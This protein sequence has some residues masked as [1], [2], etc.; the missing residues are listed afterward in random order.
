MRRAVGI[1]WLALTALA[2]AVFAPLPYVTT[3][4]SELAAD[5]S[6]LALN[7][8][9]RPSWLQAFFYAHVIGG[10]V[11]LL[12]SPVQLS[13]RIRARA[14]RLHRLSGRIVLT[15]VMAAGVAG[16][17]LSPYNLAG[18][19]GIAGF[20]LLAVLWPT[21]A[22]RGFLAIRRG[23]VTVHRQWMLRTFALTYAAVT[24]RLWLGVLVPIVGDFRS[25]YVIVPFLAWV[26][27][28]LVAEWVLRRR[29]PVDDRLRTPAL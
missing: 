27:N 12:L 21:F 23:D 19:V 16:L 22:A 7:Y 8:V 9:H 20:G 11:A 15:A 6:E 28:L 24:L 10:A 2:I 18:P 13:A 29:Q 1:W 17:V 14:P 3:S 4:L 26:P 5:K 25:A